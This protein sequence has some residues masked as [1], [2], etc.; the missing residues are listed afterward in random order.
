MNFNPFTNL[1]V[2]CVWA[3]MSRR[4]EYL[5]C[6]RLHAIIIQNLKGLTPQ[7]WPQF[8]EYFSQIWLE[9]YPPSLWKNER[10]TEKINS[11]TNN[12]L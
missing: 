5:Y 4:N 12:C 8:W 3:L 10:Q 9:K 1:F 2:P 7:N 6:E 11:R